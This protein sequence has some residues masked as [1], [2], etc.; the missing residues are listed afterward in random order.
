MMKIRRGNGAF[1]RRSEEKKIKTGH[2]RRMRRSGRKY[3]VCRLQ[4]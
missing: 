3:R 2:F 1:A 4:S